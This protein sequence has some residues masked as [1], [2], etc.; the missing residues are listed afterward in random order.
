MKFIMKTSLI[1]KIKKEL[2]KSQKPDL[3]LEAIHLLISLGFVLIQLVYLN[4]RFPVLA[5][6]VPLF[7][8]QLWG[9]AQLTSKSSL[10]LI[11]AISVVM[12]LFGLLFMYFFKSRFYKYGPQITLVSVLIFNFAL[13]ASLFRIVTKCLLV[14]TP[15]VSELVAHL[16]EP[17]LIALALSIM[18][19]PK[20]VKLMKK[21]QIV[22]DP[23]KHSHPGMILK[24]PSARG[25]G[26][27]FALLFVPLSLFFA[28]LSVENLGILTLSSVLALL[29]ILDD[30]QNTHLGS[31][32]RFLENPWVRLTLLFVVVGALH[33]F[34]IG[35]DFGSSAFVG[36]THFVQSSQNIVLGNIVIKLLS[37]L[38]TTLWIVW[39]LNLLSWSNGVDGQYS[40][41]AGI[42]LIIVSILSLR[43]GTDKPSYLGYAQIALIGA[44]I[45]LGLARVTWFPSKMMWGFGAM[46]AGLVLASLSILIQAKV[47]TS[48]LILLIPF[49][50]AIAT[51]F[52][53]I[54]S[55][56]S[57][58]KGDK[59]HFHH[60]LMARGLSERQ[61]ATFYW[62]FT[63]FFG[64]LSLLS[65]NNIQA[66]RVL[67]SLGTVF[68]VFITASLR[69]SAKKKPVPP[70]EK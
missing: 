30:I 27:F 44:G 62:V 57:P 8:T 10:F 69:L 18:L 59:E 41:I 3:S 22:T 9:E 38:L 61:V 55:G 47:I 21:W 42:S 46:S 51:L 26:L 28:P 16:L 39:T 49:L 14:D 52:R 24:N 19:S 25:G 15:L 7:Y 34:G 33:L 56:K 40:G 6:E 2:H 58:L 20:Y 50:D 48:I 70:V 45:S 37:W 60:L 35:I 54:L 4:L 66:Q 63:A 65:A 31:K 5:E 67:M 68:F 23:A 53:R 43:F 64:G 1:A 11:P 12:S 17:F 29:G 13:T 32:L 36:L